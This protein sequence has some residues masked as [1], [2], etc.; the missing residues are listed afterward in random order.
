MS[1]PPNTTLGAGGG[2]PYRRCEQVSAVCPVQLTTLGYYPSRGANYF[3]AVGF[4]LCIIVAL[5]LGTWKKTWSYMAFLVAGCALELAGYGARVALADNPWNRQAFETQIC[6]IVLGPTL[7]CISIYLTLKHVT[8]ALGPTLSRVRPRVYPFIFVPADVSCLL[9]QAIGGALA[10]SAASD[11]VPNMDLVNGGN[12]A[13]I[14]GICLQVVVLVAF[15]ALS[16]DYYVRV[17][18][19]V[20]GG[21]ADAGAVALWRDKKFRAFAGAVTVAYL[22]IL[23]RCIY[24]IAE[25]AGGWGNHI[26]Q[27]EPSF[28][29]L[30]SVMMLVASALLAVFAPGLLF[31][32]MAEA[33]NAKRD[34]EDAA[35]GTGNESQDT[36]KSAPPTSEGKPKAAP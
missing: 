13:I 4:G 34:K 8:F 25:M 33:M 3:F 1:A 26:M 36:E 10:A 27:D 31:P 15:G 17:R 5:V 22:A 11:G 18:R 7:I 14:A 29:A 35:A 20:A 23:L 2:R 28:I 19:W 9:V 32:Q 30:D 24:R 12:R 21:R 16:I 6:A